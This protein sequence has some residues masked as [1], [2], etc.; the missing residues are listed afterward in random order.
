[1][2][3][4]QILIEK[5]EKKNGNYL[6]SMLQEIQESYKYIPEESLSKV[7]EKLHIPLIDVYGVVTFYNSF[8]MVPKGEYIITVCLGT[9]CYI[10]GGR[11][12]VDTLMKELS[13]KPGETTKDK[14]FTLKTVNCLGCCA[15]GPTVQINKEFYGDM[16]PVKII[17]LIRTLKSDK[18]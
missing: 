4:E 3:T 13:V 15:I 10:R 12:L 6:I 2:I 5:S 9:A 18:K 16:T 17:D 11:I 8:S 1:M 7:A 14:K